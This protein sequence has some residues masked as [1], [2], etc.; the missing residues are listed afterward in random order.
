MRLS[1]IMLCAA[2][3][4]LAGCA[5]NHQVDFTP[6]ASSPLPSMQKYNDYVGKDY[7]VTTGVLKLCK[8]PTSFDCMDFPSAGTHLKVDGLVPNHLVN[9][10]GAT[11]DDPY[12]HVVLDDGSSSFAAADTFLAL[13]T[14]IDPAVAAEECRKKGDPKLGMNATQVAATCWGPPHYVNTTQRTTG[15][16]E[17]Y[18]YGDNKFVYLTN[19]VVTEIRVNRGGRRNAFQSMR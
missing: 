11:F 4:G 6:V 15:K 19:G 18:V 5:A 1:T 7:W 10:S 14:T 8:A 13:T 16:Y 17:Q 9:L 12:F 3:C 2:L